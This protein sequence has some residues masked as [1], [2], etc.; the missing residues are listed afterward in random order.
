VAPGFRGLLDSPGQR[1]AVAALPFPEHEGGE[2][3]ARAVTD[4]P[5]ARGEQRPGM[6]ERETQL[7]TEPDDHH[8]T[9]P[10]SWVAP[11]RHV[12]SSLANYSHPDHAKGPRSTSC[13][14][15]GP[16]EVVI[17]YPDCPPRAGPD[18]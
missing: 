18:Y 6:V 14:D 17:G 2:R 8:L 10:E 4:Q 12:A 5:D 9:E 16:L 13:V 7:D 1:L 15:R 11:E 3:P